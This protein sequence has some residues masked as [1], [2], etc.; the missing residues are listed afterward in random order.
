MC[1]ICQNYSAKITIDKI[2][3]DYC[4]ECGFL[5]KTDLFI[6]SKNTEFN[7][8]LQHENNSSEGYIKYQDNF[9]QSI[10]SYLGFE[11]LDFGCG[12][13]HIL[14]DIINGEGLNCSYYDLYFYPEENYKKRLYDAI[15]MEEVIEHLKDPIAVLKELISLLKD[16]GKLIIRTMFIP[17]DF[18]INK[19]WY[20]RDITHISF[21]DFKTFSYLSKLLSLT[22][23][24]CNDKDLIILQKA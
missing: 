7:R 24:Y 22:I 15:I 10:K 12:N 8:Y 3:Y 5:S 13:N 1:K 2:E 9:Y 20:L 18:K 6:P 14:A 4:E 11:V 19:W 21:F 16:G 23:I 17:T